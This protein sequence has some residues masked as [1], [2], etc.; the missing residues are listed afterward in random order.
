MI[1]LVA[2]RATPPSR[3]ASCPVHP[4]STRTFYAHFANVEECFGSTYR[5][6]IRLGHQSL[7]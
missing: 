4:G 2:T 1:E 7:F 3:S 6:I 5:S